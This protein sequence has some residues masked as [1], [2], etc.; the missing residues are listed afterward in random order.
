ML[1]SEWLINAGIRVNCIETLKICMEDKHIIKKF[2][3][4]FR[5]YLPFT[6]TVLQKNEFYWLDFLPDRWSTMNIGLEAVEPTNPHYYPLFIHNL[7]APGK[8]NDIVSR[9]I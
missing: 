4:D 3:T 5:I 7:D 6:F 9:D 1:A 8:I 2:G